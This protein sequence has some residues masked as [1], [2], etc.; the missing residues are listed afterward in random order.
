MRAPSCSSPKMCRLMGWPPM[1]QPPGSDTRAR[2]LRATSGPSTRLEARMVFTSSYGASGQT[3]FWVVSF[4]APSRTSTV[5]PISTSRR[6]MVRISRTRG[7]RCRVT[8]SSV[9]KAAASAGSAEFFEP[10]VEISPFSETPP[11]ITNL[12]MEIL[13][14]R[15]LFGERPRHASAGRGQAV[16]RL[17]ARHAGFAHHNGRAHAIAAGGEQFRRAI[18]TDAGALG[19]DAAGAL[20]QLVIGGLNVHHQV[21]V[22]ITQADERL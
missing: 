10:L 16:L 11:V 14:L 15:G 2:L 22:Y 1:A 3:I 8:G 21:A 6:S 7:T 18:R 17:F 20:D 13:F 19:N 4:T 9:S 12:S 5:L